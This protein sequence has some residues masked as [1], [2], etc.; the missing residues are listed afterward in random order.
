METVAADILGYDLDLDRPTAA[1]YEMSRSGRDCF[2]YS[3]LQAWGLT[4]LA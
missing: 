2:K 3:D 4:H 1:R